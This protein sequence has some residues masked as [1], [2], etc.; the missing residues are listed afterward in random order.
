MRQRFMRL[1]FTSPPTRRNIS[2]TPAAN[3]QRL[4]YIRFAIV[5][6]VDSRSK[7]QH[8]NVR[9]RIAPLRFVTVSAIASSATTTACHDAIFVLCTT[10]PN[11]PLSFAMK[12]Q[13]T[14]CVKILPKR[15][16]SAQCGFLCF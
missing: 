11:G 1:R 6:F 15:H 3:T 9:F 8:D 14:D 7:I 12:I 13:K 2:M 4:A 5:E 10:M 16:F